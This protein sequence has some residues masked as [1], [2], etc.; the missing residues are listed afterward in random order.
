MKLTFSKKWLLLWLLPAWCMAVQVKPDAPGTYVVKKGDTLWDISSLYLEQPWQWPELWRNNPTISNPHLIFPGDELRLT[1]NADGE[2]ELLVSR[3][4]PLIKISPTVERM[5]KSAEPVPVLPWSVIEPYLE[6]GLV[7]TEEA[8]LGLPKLL[9]DYDGGIRF[10]EGDLVLGQNDAGLD[11]MIVLR[12]Q[13]VLY[14]MD[15][16]PLGVQVRHVADAS[17]VPTEEVSMHLVRV[18]ASNFEATQ[19]DRLASA[20]TLPLGEE[21]RL[22]PAGQQRGFVIGNLR[23]HNMMGKLDVVALDLGEYQNMQPGTVMGI[24]QP[25]PSISARDKPEYVAGTTWF[26]KALGEEEALTAPPMKIGELVVFKVFDK[27]SYA[28]IT[29]ASK[30]VT[31]GAIVAH[32]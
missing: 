20:D 11:D 24:Y 16:N 19:G 12:K 4:K 22:T 13:N 21:I 14:D 10:A 1:V 17:L 15:D 26:S 30:M 23:E 18:K 7:M 5:Q 6:H 9:G 29:K 2:P 25:G 32:P 27:T 31:R 8:Y 28:L 3:A